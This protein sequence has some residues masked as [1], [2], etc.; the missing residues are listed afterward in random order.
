VSA[1]LFSQ[2]ELTEL[3]ATINGGTPLATVNNPTGNTWYRD[4]DTVLAWPIK[5]HE[6]FTITPSFSFFNVF[7]FANFAPVGS[8][9]TPLGAL[10]GGPGT[11]N[12]TIAGN[13]QTHNVLR[14]GLG[15][16]VFAAGAPRQAEFGLRID[17]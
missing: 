12:G 2:T 17:F 3:G 14:D 7:N 15:S 13:D 1:G 4:F 9:T 11:P 5:I 10:N 6:R 8:L 16:G